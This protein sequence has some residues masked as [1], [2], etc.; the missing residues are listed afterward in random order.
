MGRY[1]EIWREQHLV[2]RPLLEAER[3]LLHRLG[4]ADLALGQ[5]VVA[6]VLEAER[7]LLVRVRVRV[8]VGVRVSS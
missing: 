6:L 7:A 5:G 4:E 1:G 2:V 3:V 8:R